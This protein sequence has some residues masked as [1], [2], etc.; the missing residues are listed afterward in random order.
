MV[1]ELLAALLAVVVKLVPL[2][3]LLA[4]VVQVVQLALLAVLV[5]HL[6]VVIEAF[7]CLV[8]SELGISAALHHPIGLD[9]TQTK[10]ATFAAVVVL[11]TYLVVVV[12]LAVSAA[13]TNPYFCPLVAVQEVGRLA[14][15]S[16]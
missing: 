11:Y 16:T 13:P 10:T 12:A 1:A 7:P 2:A 3:A 6:V 8:V 15:E 14:V 5:L 9:W 4:V